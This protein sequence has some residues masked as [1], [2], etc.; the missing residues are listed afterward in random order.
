MPLPDGQPPELLEDDDELL[1]LELELDEE[2]LLEDDEL[3]LPLLELPESEDPELLLEPDE[4]LDELLLLELLSS[5]DESSI[6]GA[7]PLVF[8]NTS[9]KYP[10]YPGSVKCTIPTFPSE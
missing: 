6:S 10:Q 7:S 1:L 9:L 5:L 4:E 3:E 2:E 8:I